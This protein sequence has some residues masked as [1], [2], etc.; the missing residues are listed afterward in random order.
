MY[1]YQIFK[2]DTLLIINENELT[3]IKYYHKKF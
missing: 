2:Y 1:Y 3:F